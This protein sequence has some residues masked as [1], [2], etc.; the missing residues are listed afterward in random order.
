MNENEFRVENA[1]TRVIKGDLA[2]MHTDA[3][4]EGNAYSEKLTGILTYTDI[5]EGFASQVVK[6]EMGEEGPSEL[7]TL[8]A[9]Q[10]KLI[11][12][13][14]SDAERCKGSL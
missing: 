6:E 2:D 3:W 9:Q 13:E 1:I 12:N 10:I 5:V 7:R 14:G 4:T 8:W 11:P